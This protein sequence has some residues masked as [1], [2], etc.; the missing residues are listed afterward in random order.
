MT[1]D[2]IRFRGEGGNA[3]SQRAATFTVFPR[4]FP[5]VTPIVIRRSERERGGRGERGGGEEGRRLDDIYLP[6]WLSSL[7]R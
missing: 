2:E 4:G 1:F 3:R 7:H 5:L 6:T